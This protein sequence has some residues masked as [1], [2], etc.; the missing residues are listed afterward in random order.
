M[1]ENK[2]TFPDFGTRVSLTENVVDFAKKYGFN[3]V[4]FDSGTHKNEIVNVKYT[5]ATEKAT[6]KN[7]DY[8]K[9]LENYIKNHK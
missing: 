2:R 8:I 6:C 3:A 4:R 7:A 1:T 5:D 9:Y